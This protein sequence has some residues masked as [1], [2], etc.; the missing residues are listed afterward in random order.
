M[1]WPICHLTLK[2]YEMTKFIDELD[3]HHL[4]ELN[5]LKIK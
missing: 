1:Q 2:L 5:A 3:R 4:I